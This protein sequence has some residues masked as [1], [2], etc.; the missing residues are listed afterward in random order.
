MFNL[1]DTYDDFHVYYRYPEYGKRDDPYFT[2]YL[3]RFGV[4]LDVSCGDVASQHPELFQ[5]A[6]QSA[7]LTQKDLSNR[8]KRCDDW[9][10]KF[11]AFEPYAFRLHHGEIINDDGKVIK[12]GDSGY[13]TF[14][15][16]DN[17][18]KR[19]HPDEDIYN[20]Y[21]DYDWHERIVEEE[22]K[23][24]YDS[25]ESMVAKQVVNGFSA[26]FDK[27]ITANN[28]TVRQVESERVNI[29]QQIETL[30]REKLRLEK[31]QRELEARQKAEAQRKAELEA[32]K[33]RHSTLKLNY[34]T[35][36]ELRSMPT[37]QE[38]VYLLHDVSHT[39]TYKIGKAVN[40]YNRLHRFEV[41]LP[42]E[43][44]VV[45]LL[46]TD[47]ALRLESVKH[48]KYQHRHVRGEW[49]ALTDDEVIEFLQHPGA[50]HAYTDS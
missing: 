12:D 44:G 41:K 39:G 25:L 14:E 28:A 30:Q 49:Y 35:H 6:L 46:P 38:Y 15:I 50:I 37:D 7:L 23:K 43:T 29:A 26:G 36:S 27:I 1:R 22:K 31:V 24:V 8:I 45:C 34:L 13:L 48:Q 47:N 32:Q 5:E 33:G 11:F 10:E 21:I 17:W 40:P 18:Y 16:L 2:F 9:G 3:M 19:N 4:A 20:R 42:I